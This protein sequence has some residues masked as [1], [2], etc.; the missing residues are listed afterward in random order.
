MGNDQSRLSA[1][2]NVLR[3]GMGAGGDLAGGQPIKLIAVDQSSGAGRVTYRQNRTGGQ[4]IDDLVL[5]VLQTGVGINTTLLAAR[6]DDRI[7][8]Q[9][10]RSDHCKSESGDPVSPSFAKDRMSIEAVGRH[11]PMHSAAKA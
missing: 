7:L 3:E 1:W 2:E 8:R 4:I 11:L 9:S 6:D 10:G 5:R